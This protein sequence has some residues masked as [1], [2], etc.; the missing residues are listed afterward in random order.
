MI[1]EAEPKNH[2]TVGISD[3]VTHTSWSEPS[4]HRAERVPGCSMG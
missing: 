2:F 3:D 1:S 4:F